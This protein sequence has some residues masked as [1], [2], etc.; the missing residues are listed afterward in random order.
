MSWQA[1]RVFAALA[2]AGSL[3]FGAP[4]C[5]DDD[6]DTRATPAPAEGPR[7]VVGG[8]TALRV[9]PALEGALD[10][11]GIEI[12]PAGEATRT[13]G[14]LRLPI[15]GGEVDIGARTGTLQ[16]QGGLRFRVPGADIEA[17]DVVLDT[18]NGA[19]TAQVGGNR[20]SLLRVDLGQPRDR[21]TEGVYAWTGPARLGE[22]AAAMINDRV[23]LDVARVGLPLGDVTVNAEHR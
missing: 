4:A 9:S 21:R 22:D 11:A 13:D 5:G 2:V 6:P 3:A 18:R 8:F 14:A 10:L 23:G 7:E 19:M 15:D 16:H 20:I 1:V 12:G 17:T